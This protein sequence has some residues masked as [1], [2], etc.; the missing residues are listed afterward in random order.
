M[1]PF[2]GQLTFL[3]GDMRWGT[4]CI[5]DIAGGSI[6]AIRRWIY[7]IVTVVERGNGGEIRRI[8]V[9]IFRMKGAQLSVKF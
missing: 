2:V 7:R 5:V 3:S 9:G 1:C 8:A 6:R 4:D